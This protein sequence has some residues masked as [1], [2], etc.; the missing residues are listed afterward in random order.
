MRDS[1][2]FAANIT[3]TFPVHKIVL[4]QQVHGH[5]LHKV[6]SLLRVEGLGL[7]YRGM[8]PPLL[9]QGMSKALMFGAYD[10]SLVYAK[11]LLGREG[12]EGG[13]DTLAVCLAALVS[14]TAEVAFMPFERVQTLLQL[15][16]Y[17]GHFRNTGHAFR[18]IYLEYGAREFYRGISAILLRNGPSNALFF[19]LRHHVMDFRPENCG[20]L[21]L[22]AY[23]FAY[24]ALLG[25]TCSTIFYPL[26][27]I[28]SNMMKR[29]GGKFISI[30]EALR[31]CLD[32]RGS[33]RGVRPP[34]P[35]CASPSNRSPLSL[36][37]PP[38][39]S[40]AASRST[41]RAPCSRGASST[42]YTK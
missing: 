12:G 35:P 32:Q 16:E 3:L 11:A 38:L 8:L 42:L 24:G 25:A 27:V 17:H 4:R 13:K 26:N 40:T 23:N 18:L 34:L 2:R 5:V 31:A 14:G 39:S 41:L 30:A 15:P 19:G 37:P 36:P 33:L 22:S 7:L 29:C 6:L 1:P 28:K 10:K 21:E 9:Q 20:P